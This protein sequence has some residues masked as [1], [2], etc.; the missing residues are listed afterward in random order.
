MPDV[1]DVIPSMGQPR[2]IM[3]RMTNPQDTDRESVVRQRLANLSFQEI[4][5]MVTHISGILEH[6]AAQR[7]DMTVERSRDNDGWTIRVN[8]SA[9]AP[10]PPVPA[11]NPLIANPSAA[12]RH[13]P[14]PPTTIGSSR[15]GKTTGRMQTN[16]QCVLCGNA[17]PHRRNRPQL[18]C[19]CCLRTC[20]TP[21][22]PTIPDDVA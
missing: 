18:D 11:P 19:A 14:P 15:S 3:E 22:R 20:R 5:Q 21:D 4:D 7:D 16:G 6:L 10:E 9:T 8:L 1:D 13:T 17:H 2:S 12:P